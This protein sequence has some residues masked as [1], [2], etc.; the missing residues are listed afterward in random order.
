LVGG[1]G[2]V[3]WGMVVHLMT[4][5]VLGVIF[6]AIIGPHVSSAAAAALWRTGYGLLVMVAMMYLVLPWANPTM[7]SR[8]PIMMGAQAIGHVLYGMCLGLAPAF[9]ARSE[10]VFLD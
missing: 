3:M 2:V 9:I 6:A 5:A 1:I 10:R 8:V 7:A 4:S